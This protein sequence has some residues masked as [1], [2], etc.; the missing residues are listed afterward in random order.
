MSLFLILKK[1]IFMNPGKRILP[2]YSYGVL[3][4]DHELKA[5]LIF[6]SDKNK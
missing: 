5:G 1:V 6:F 4:L 2:Y 3:H